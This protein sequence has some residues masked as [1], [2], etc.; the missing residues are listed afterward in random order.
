MGAEIC[1]ISVYGSKLTSFLCAG[2]KRLIFVW[3]SI[4]L[5]FVR[6][7]ENY[8]FRYAGRKAFS[9]SVVIEM[10]LLFV[11]VVEINLIS[12]LRMELRLDSC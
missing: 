11:W 4:D 6:V 5:S 9:F 10:D 8:L 1:L 3:G 7:V 2:R 12:V